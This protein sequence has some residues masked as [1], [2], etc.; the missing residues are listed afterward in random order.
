M[1]KSFS[2][3]A[4]IGV[5]CTL[6]YFAGKLGLSLAVVHPSETAVWPPTGIALAAVLLLGQRVW[7]GILLGAFLVN[8]TTAGSI[9]TFLGIATG[10]TLEALFGAFLM[11]RFANGSAAFDRSNDVVKFVVLAG[12]ASTIISATLGVTSRLLK[13]AV[14]PST[15]LRACPEF[16]EGTNGGG[17]ESLENFCSCWGSRSTRTFFHQPASAKRPRGKRYILNDCKLLLWPSLL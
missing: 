4:T 12:M 13:K 9:A 2:D 16:I 11:R 5:V 14:H 10:N 1:K 15:K 17:L 6:Y 8:V 3:L 7:P